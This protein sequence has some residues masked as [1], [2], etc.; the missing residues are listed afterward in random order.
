MTEIFKPFPLTTKVLVGNM[1][2]KRN[3][4]GGAWI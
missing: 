2:R 3:G 4:F 1:G